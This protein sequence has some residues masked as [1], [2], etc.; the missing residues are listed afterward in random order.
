MFIILNET[1]QDEIFRGHKIT[2]P[3]LM[4]IRVAG[5]LGGRN[6]LREA[7]EFFQSLYIS[8]KQRLFEREFSKLMKYFGV[9]EE[10]KITKIEPIG[11]DLI[12]SKAWDV[13][14]SDEKREL[15]GKDPLPKEL[16]PPVVTTT[17]PDVLP[18]PVLPK[19][20]IKNKAIESFLAKGQIRKG[21]VLSSRSVDVEFI[22][23]GEVEK[24]YMAELTDV[25]LKPIEL[26]VIDLL[27]KDNLMSAENIGKVIGKSAKE[28]TKVIQGLKEK[29]LLKET[30]EGGVT[31]LKPVPDAKKILGE[32]P[33]PTEEIIVEY[34]YEWREGF[35][36]ENKGTSRDFCIEMRD[37][38][39]SGKRWLREDIEMLSNDLDTD[40]WS[41]RGGFYTLPGTDT[42][43]PSCRHIWKQHAK[44]IQR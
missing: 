4:G 22:K 17:P 10:L 21:R 35:S 5:Q 11:M 33:A 26:S 12:N 24:Q 34:S 44:L 28:V 8:P 9:K 36:D 14:T 2:S 37:A 43:R 40:V 3:M 42:H 30:K 41:T 15:I 20:P 23:L 7:S 25:T 6:E 31:S 39:N 38:S 13:L 18:K 32:T 29:D 1:I 16:T 19:N 27:E